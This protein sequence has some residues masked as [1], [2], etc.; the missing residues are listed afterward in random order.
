MEWDSAEPP[1]FTKDTIRLNGNGP[2]G[3][4]AFLVKRVDADE[5]ASC[6][7]GKKPYDRCVIACLVVL[8]DK[9]GFEIDLAAIPVDE[10]EME[11]K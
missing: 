6:N 10:K 8:R 3:S 2:D 11:G 7:T 1:I 4:Q 9:L 5:E